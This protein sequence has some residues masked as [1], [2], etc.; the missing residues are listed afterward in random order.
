MSKKTKSTLSI[1]VALAIMGFIF[2]SSSMSYQ[3]QSLVSKIQKW[4]PGQPFSEF[5]SQINF[6]YAGTTISVPSLGYAQ[7]I[8]FF[9]RKATHFIVY[10]IIGFNWA[11]GLAGHMKQKPLAYLLAILI[12]VLYAGADE[13]HQGITPGRTPLIQDVL[14]DS[15]GGLLGI[16]IGYFKRF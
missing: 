16:A 15:A 4:L 13:F 10:F 7:F 14:L 9:I 8:E 2:Y 1:I 12:T 11:R 6:K 5:L 3:D